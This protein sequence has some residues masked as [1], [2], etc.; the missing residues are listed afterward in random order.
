VWGALSRFPTVSSLIRSFARAHQPKTR[1]NVPQAGCR[2]VFEGNGMHLVLIA[3][4]NVKV[5]RQFTRTFAYVG[6]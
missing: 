1:H 4:V 6:F 5:Q 3:T 2:M